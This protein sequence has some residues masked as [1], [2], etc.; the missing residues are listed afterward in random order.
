[1]LKLDNQKSYRVVLGVVL[2]AVFVCFLRCLPFTV[3][4]GDTGELVADAFKYQIPHPSGY[5]LFINL[6][7]AFIH[8]TGWATSSALGWGTVFY[9]A[10][11][12]TCLLSV[13]T[14]ALIAKTKG[15]ALTRYFAIT[16][17]VS[18]AVSK[19]FWRYS[20]LPDVYAL[21]CLLC[22]GVLWFYVNETKNSAIYATLLFSLCMTNHVTALALAPVVLHLWLK[23][24]QRNRFF[25][26]LGASALVLILLY[27]SLLKMNPES[28]YSWGRI[29]SPADVMRH[30]LR[31]D[32]GR[33]RK[34]LAEW[35]ESL[36][37][38]N[39]ARA[40]EG[41][42]SGSQFKKEV[43][44]GVGNLLNPLSPEFIFYGKNFLNQTCTDLF[45]VLLCLLVLGLYALSRRRG[46][47]RAWIL[48][49]ITLIY[50]YG[51]FALIKIKPQPDSLIVTERFLLLPQILLCFAAILLFRSIAEGEPPQ[52][53]LIRLLRCLV[54]L[55]MLSCVSNVYHYAGALN[56]SDNTIVEDYALNWF[57]TIPKDVSALVLV[58][59]DTQYY[60][61]RYVQQVFDKNPK[62][63]V[64]SPPLLFHPWYV[65]KITESDPNL[66]F[67]SKKVSTTLEMNLAADLIDPNI[68]D[69]YFY[70][71]GKYANANHYH[72]TWSTLGRRL[73]RKVDSKNSTA[74]DADYIVAKEPLQLRSGLEVIRTPFLEYDP[75]RSLFAEYAEPILAQGLAFATEHN[76]EGAKA[77]FLSALERVPYCLPALRGLCALIEL[78][79]PENGVNL[80]TSKITEKCKNSL[81]LMT[82]SQ[83]D[84]F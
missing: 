45:P 15:N 73:V 64:L 41:N 77:S 43:A 58:Q 32:Y 81:N 22:A 78:E 38:F 1:M 63:R 24:P 11:L 79:K 72:F 9:R 42:V 7:Y 70:A 18:F 29:Q 84:Y 26:T 54:L 8:I 30:F 50:C 74:T 2:L 80:D 17:A 61:L 55:P 5:P 48:L 69:H 4:Y 68:S 13:G 52:K 12:F 21:H 46:D 75:A 27:G 23:S 36:S 83:L 33:N 35:T 66:K 25:T 60:S 40:S 20:V 14:V 31:E 47:T 19:I 82:A 51:I 37:L 56:Y 49:G 10:S 16:V 39:Q 44:A 6:Y 76:F 71:T 34:S 62:T 65:A 57:K 3:Q 59:N 53:D 28:F 67:N